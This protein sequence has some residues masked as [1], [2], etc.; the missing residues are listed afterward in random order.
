MIDSQLQVFADVAVAVALDAGAILRGRFGQPHDV[1]FK[2]PLDLVTEADKAAEEAIASHL[3]GAF[4]EHDLLGEEG[5]RSENTGARYRWVIDP[6]DGTTNFAHGLPTFAVSIALEDAGKPVVGVVYD[7]M[8][9]ELFRAIQ[10]GG[11]TLNGES[12]NVSDVDRVNRAVLASGFAHDQAQ[13]QRQGAAWCAVLECVQGLRQTG[14]AALNLCYV[15]AGRIDGYWERGIQPW[16]VSAGALLVS[17]A[18]GMVSDRAGGPFD[19]HDRVVV[20]T[21]G[22]LHQE[23]L[24][25]LGQ[26]PDE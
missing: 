22:R 3:R 1:S 24:T 12:I 25:I 13:R 7:P 11:S 19:A 21:N 20:A 26:Y 14:S 5:S 10:G 2:G 9:N 17:E 18:G 15:A 8:R 16:D 23:L 6:L 4:P